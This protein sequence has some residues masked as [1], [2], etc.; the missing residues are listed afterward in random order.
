MVLITL[1]FFLSLTLRIIAGL[2]ICEFFIYWLPSL[3][4]CG[5][6]RFFQIGKWLS[7]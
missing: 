2:I 6:R 1:S 5:L 7:L 4:T 3:L